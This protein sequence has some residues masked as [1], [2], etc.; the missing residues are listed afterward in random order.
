[1]P[2]I[3]SAACARGCRFALDDFG[4]GL[5]SFG[6]LKSLPVD[7]LKIDG[8]FVRGVEHDSM[9]LAMGDSINQIGH[10]AGMQTIAEYVENSAIETRLRNLGVDYV[11][12]YAIARPEPLQRL[13][14]VPAPRIKTPRNRA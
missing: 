2:C 1:M 4:S 6:Y 11:Q 13:A 8:R 7:Y 10:V 9:D 12:G 5:G 14:S 3:S